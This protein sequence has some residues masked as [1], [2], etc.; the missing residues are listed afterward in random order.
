MIVVCHF[1]LNTFVAGLERCVKNAQVW[2]APALT[3]ITIGSSGEQVCQMCHVIFS[4]LSNAVL[5]V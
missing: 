5:T 1:S 4:S 2:I 3:V